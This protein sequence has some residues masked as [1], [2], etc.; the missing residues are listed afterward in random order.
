[1]SQSPASTSRFTAFWLY[2]RRDDW[3]EATHGNWDAAV[4]EFAAVLADT[5]VEVRGVYSS[6]GLRADVDLIIWAHAPKLD[7][8]SALAVQLDQTTIG[9][10]LKRVDG[11]IGTAGM[12]QYDPNHGPAF[13][14]GLPARRYLSVYPFIKTPEWFLIDFQERR[15][16]MIEHGQLGAPWPDLLTNTVESFGIQ[17]QEFIVALEDDDPKNIVDM[18]KKLRDAEVRVYTALDTP[19]YLGERMT[20]EEA[21]ASIRG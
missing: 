16:M 18:V 13:I 2:A 17:D 20:T 5:D 21:L 3:R 1:M 19:I 7:R 9:R 4:V 10:A 12:S 15:R 8:V 6:L 14:K 11:Y